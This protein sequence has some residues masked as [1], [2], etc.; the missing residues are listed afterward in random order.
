FF[1]SPIGKAHRGPQVDGPKTSTTPNI[2]AKRGDELAQVKN[3]VDQLV[4][5]SL[6]WLS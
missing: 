3:N 6:G 1:T 4:N 2:S 5:D